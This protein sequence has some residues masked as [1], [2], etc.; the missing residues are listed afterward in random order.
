MV[1][2]RIVAPW[3]IRITRGWFLRLTIAGK[4]KNTGRKRRRRERRSSWLAVDRQGPG[5]ARG[6]WGTEGGWWVPVGM[7][8]ASPPSPAGPARATG[9]SLPE[10]HSQGTPAVTWNAR[11]LSLRVFI[12]PYSKAPS[13]QDAFLVPLPGVPSDFSKAC[14]HL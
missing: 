9:R 2:E 1:S 11:S 7:S 3:S 12:K 4:G 14:S 10:V 13:L 5:R 6:R 8:P